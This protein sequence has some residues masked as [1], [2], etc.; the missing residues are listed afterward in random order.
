MICSPCV[1]VYV[2]VQC[3][4]EANYAHQQ[5]LDMIPLMMH[6]DYKPQGWRKYDHQVLNGFFTY[7]QSMLLTWKSLLCG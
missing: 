2:S 6:K 3:R 1:C 7:P 5:E 4:L